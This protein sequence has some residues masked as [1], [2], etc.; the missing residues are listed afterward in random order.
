MLNCCKK[1][2]K[3]EKKNE[4]D[5][6]KPIPIS[7]IKIKRG[8]TYPTNTNK[9]LFVDEEIKFNISSK[10][11]LII[12][13][14]NISKKIIT[15]IVSELGYIPILIN[16]KSTAIQL[17]YILKTIKK[18][19]QTQ[20]SLTPPMPS[21]TIMKKYAPPINKLSRNNTVIVKSSKNEYV[22]PKLLVLLDNNFLANII[23]GNELI[24]FLIGISYVNVISM[25]SNRLSF[26]DYPE[27]PF[28]L[29]PFSKNA[30]K[31]I[32]MVNSYFNKN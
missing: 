1:K 28:I 32:L 31:E 30:L 22:C 14:N 6:T 13:D 24:E 12:E 7:S 29:K 16:Y 11:C 8:K 20:I 27:I 25:S 3:I 2:E 26:K 15:K 5:K 21:L 19:G 9:I 17:E 23:T 4:E 18:Y 10:Y